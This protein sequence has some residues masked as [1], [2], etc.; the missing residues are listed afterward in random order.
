MFN[1][2]ATKV[3]E[4][5]TGTPP[6]QIKGSTTV[7]IAVGLIVGRCLT[8][9]EFE[10]REAWEMLD[11][12][13]K[14]AVVHHRPKSKFAE[15]FDQD[16]ERQRQAA[17]DRDQNESPIAKQWRQRIERSMMDS[18]II[19]MEMKEPLAKALAVFCKR[20]CID[21]VRRFA[22][23]EEEAWRML[24]AIEELRLALKHVG[25]SPDARW[26]GG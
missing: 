24:W 3:E 26:I 14:K 5:A 20:S 9:T 11:D 1:Q 21:G 22:E 25:L 16:I 4:I 7:R 12:V 8:N 13:Q 10:D 19:E 23:N 2:I 17:I 6:E 15:W 18:Y